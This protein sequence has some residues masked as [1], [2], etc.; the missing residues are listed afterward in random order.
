MK[1]LDYEHRLKKLGWTTLEAR[2][3]RG[4]L[5][6]TY[7]V[8]HHNAS[9]DLTSWHWAQPLTQAQGPARSVRANDAR[10]NPPIRHNCKQREN[11]ITSRVAAPLRE[12]PAG[13]MN[14]ASVNNFKNAYDKV[15]STTTLD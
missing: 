12:L 2:R 8:L 9:A 15:I 1:G 14:A 7:Q 11:F 13:I 3:Q 5:I 10:L 6:L 4:D